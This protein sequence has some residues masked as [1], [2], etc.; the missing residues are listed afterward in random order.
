[1]YPSASRQAS[2]MGWSGGGGESPELLPFVRGADMVLS[3][4]VAWF[5]T[6]TTIAQKPFCRSL[7]PVKVPHAAKERG[8]R[9]PYYA[10]GSGRATSIRSAA[11]ISDPSSVLGNDGHN[12]RR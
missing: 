5:M 9:D 4:I 12:G 2:M 3:D 6:A 10:C 7:R 8:R 11:A 1:M